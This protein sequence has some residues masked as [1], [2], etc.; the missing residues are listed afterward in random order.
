MYIISS[1]QAQ[2]V[3]RTLKY[4]PYQSSAHR[5]WMLCIQVILLYS[6]SVFQV[7]LMTVVAG[8]LF[9]AAHDRWRRNTFVWS[10]ITC[11]T[12]VP[13]IISPYLLR[14]GTNSLCRF[15]HSKDRLLSSACWICV[16]S[17][18]MC[19]QQ[20][21]ETALL[22]TVNDVLL[23]GVPRKKADINHL[24]QASIPKVRCF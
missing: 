12:T 7:R 13:I 21:S 14:I 8:Y 3:R 24:N 2:I 18:Q 5:R 22:S 1:S 9:P 19:E 20:V 15:I 6:G 10:C 23:S 16:V 17:S 11:M 4:K